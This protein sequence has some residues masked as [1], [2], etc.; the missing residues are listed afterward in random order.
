MTKGQTVS[1]FAAD[2]LPKLR[3]E[4][5]FCG[6]YLDKFLK[7]YYNKTVIFF[8]LTAVGVLASAVFSYF[9]EKLSISACLGLLSARVA[10][11]EET[12]ALQSLFAN[13]TDFL[14]N[15]SFCS[16]TGAFFMPSLKRM[17]VSRICFSLTFTAFTLGNP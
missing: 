3:R 16:A 4:D 6:E 11:V 14:I 7:I 8:S 17:L 9:I 2:K 12:T 10:E 13:L 5:I 15:P 1:V